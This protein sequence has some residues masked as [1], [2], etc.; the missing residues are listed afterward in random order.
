[1][2]EGCHFEKIKYDISTNVWLIMMKS[3]LVM[4]IGFANLNVY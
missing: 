1:M 3:G 2:A 4:D